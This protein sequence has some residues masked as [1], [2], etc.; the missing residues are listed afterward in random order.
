MR[1]K[2]EA[3]TDTGVVDRLVG[4]DTKLGA[5]SHCSGRRDSVGLRG[6]AAEVSAGYIGDLNMQCQTPDMS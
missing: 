3:Q 6:V 1:V 5:C 2:I 4:V